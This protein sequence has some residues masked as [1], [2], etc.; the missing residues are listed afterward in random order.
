[1][2][3]NAIS[4]APHYFVTATGSSAPIFIVSL[5]R[6]FSSVSDSSARDPGFDTWSSH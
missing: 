6:A 4:R 5:H 1:M 3:I 2:A